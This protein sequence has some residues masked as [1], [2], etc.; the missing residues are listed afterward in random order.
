MKHLFYKAISLLLA[1]LLLLSLTSCGADTEPESSGTEPESSGIEAGIEDTAVSSGRGRFVESALEQPGDGRI[2]SALTE[3]GG[4]L[5]F[6]KYES[7]DG[8]ESWT[9]TAIPAAVSK[10]AEDARTSV[11]ISWGP[12]GEAFYVCD[13]HSENSNDVTYY[14]YYVEADG[15]ERELDISIPEA[16]EGMAA[17]TIAFK[18]V[19]LP[20]GSIAALDN[21]NCLMHIDQNTGEIL[22]SIRYNYSGDTYYSNC[23]VVENALILNVYTYDGQLLELYDLDTWEKMPRDEVLN[24]FIKEP[25]GRTYLESFSYDPNDLPFGCSGTI[26]DIFTCPGEDAVYIATRRG[27]YRHV[28]GGTAMERVME[29]S[30]YSLGDPSRYISDLMKTAS[31]DFY[32]TC[33]DDSDGSESILRWHYD[34]DQPAAPETELQIFAMFDNSE[35][36]RAASIYQRENPDVKI[37]VEIGIEKHKDWTLAQVSQALMETVKEGGGP[38]IIL[39]DGMPYRQF[40]ENGLLEDITGLTGGLGVLQNL[41][42]AFDVEGRS[43]IVPAR[44]SVPIIIGDKDVLASVTDLGSFAG[45]IEALNKAEP[46]KNVFALHESLLMEKLAVGSSAAWYREDGSIDREKLS[47]FM[48]L[49]ARIYKA[50]SAN[51]DTLP[52]SYSPGNCGSLIAGGWAQISR[53]TVNNHMTFTSM[54]ATEEKYGLGHIALCGQAEKVFTPYC[55]M[56]I[57]STGGNKELSADFLKLAL[58]SGAQSIAPGSENLPVN[59]TALRKMLGQEDISGF[60]GPRVD[61]GQYF[62]QCRTASEEQIDEFLDF[63]G[64]LETPSYGSENLYSALTKSGAAY[65]KGEIELEA[66]LDRIIAAES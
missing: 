51:P 45:Q 61:D 42:S 62:V 17:N 60:G 10:L 54:L 7:G 36:R 31:G 44:F 32:A 34:P 66:A 49:C 35:L 21:Y 28:L 64:T 13:E 27:L 38:D 1:G 47:E 22:H 5:R 26:Q 55:L 41:A 8:G 2:S 3:A 16:P 9:E 46:E 15:T 20:D 25:D 12:D 48:Q 19:I 29:G 18:S 11:S 43:Y 53:D 6:G 14:Y 33:S 50:G 59:E 40:I 56:G 24:S 58:S 4:K 65:L 57:S 63:V 30:M 37:S 23:Y 39:L 52:M